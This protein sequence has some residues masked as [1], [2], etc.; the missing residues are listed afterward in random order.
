MET[1]Q[2]GF[3]ER[4]HSR[5]GPE[6]E[7]ILEREPWH[8]G[9][10]ERERAPL[11]AVQEVRRT[12]ERR[13]G[14]SEKRLDPDLTTKS[15]WRFLVKAHQDSFLGDLGPMKDTTEEKEVEK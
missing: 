4:G 13:Q 10:R 15:F 6:L 5:K 14:L 3:R 11:P 9:R 2:R 8:R 1:T 12:G 7:N